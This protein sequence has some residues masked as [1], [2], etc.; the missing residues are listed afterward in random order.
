MKDSGSEHFEYCWPTTCPNLPQQRPRTIYS[1]RHDAICKDPPP[2]PI[3]AFH[4]HVPRSAMPR[5]CPFGLACIHTPY[6][7]Y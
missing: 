7:M 2:R 3:N 4:T 1:H 6:M 5:S